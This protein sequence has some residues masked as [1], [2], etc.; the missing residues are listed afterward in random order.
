MIDTDPQG[1]TT[2]GFGINKNEL[3][4]TIYE[5]ILG[6]CSIRD[7]I[8][9]N[10]IENVDIIPSNVNLAASEI[11]LIGVDKKRIYSQE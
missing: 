5:L 4:N 10:A 7:C 6:D 9:G 8:I 2:S 3:E 1:N 11:E